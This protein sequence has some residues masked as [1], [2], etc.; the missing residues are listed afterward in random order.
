MPDVEQFKLP[1]VGEGLTEADILAW[2]VKVGDTI[3]INDILVEVET[4]KSVVELPSP[5]AGVVTAIHVAAGETADVGA[6]IV[7]IGDPSDATAPPP[8]GGGAS[9][10][11]V[12]GE[13]IAIDSPAAPDFPP[14]D[15]VEEVEERQSVL[16]GYGPTKAKVAR[17]PRRT[18][19]ARP[20]GLASTVDN[21]NRPCATP[22]VRKFARDL[23]VDLRAVPASGE[24][25]RISQS[26]VR[27]FAARSA[28]GAPPS[29]DEP[30]ETRIPIKAVRKHTADAMVA[31]PFT[32]PHF[33]EW[34]TVDV[35]RTLK[36]LDRMKAD[37]SFADV[38]LSPLVLVMRAALLSMGRH[39]EANA[40]WD[41][42]AGEIVQL[43]DVSLGI[44]AAIPRGLLV[45]NIRAA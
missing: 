45:P 32:A 2:H 22:P 21:P 38:R 28:S 42:A 39:P 36:L 23:G 11:P 13:P 18:A 31:S 25:G 4:A 3:E 7:S 14:R 37:R 6:P 33:T 29:A 40:K 30:Y 24:L 27:S 17:R 20:V 41:G 34:V 44:A 19:V 1:D 8:L 12:A 16:V 10:A 43:R 9:G 26:D 35:T 15:A 5:F